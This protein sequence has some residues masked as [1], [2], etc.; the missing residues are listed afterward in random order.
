VVTTAIAALVTTG[1]FAPIVIA[2][3]TFSGLTE[4]SASGLWWPALQAI[5]APAFAIGALFVALALAIRA[6]S[7][8]PAG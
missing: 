3:I 5:S 6:A 1:V 2:S 4:L 7:R 8:Q